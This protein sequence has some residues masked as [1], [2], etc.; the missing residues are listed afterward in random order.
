M[1]TVQERVRRKQC[2]NST[3]GKQKVPLATKDI[4]VQCNIIETIPCM[5][6]PHNLRVINN[7]PF[8]Q[9]GSHRKVNDNNC[10]TEISKASLR[11]VDRVVYTEP[12]LKVKMRRV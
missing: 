4:G 10:L 11:R 3:G 2:N 1:S 7:F 8:E 12:S 5:K 9:P 6:L